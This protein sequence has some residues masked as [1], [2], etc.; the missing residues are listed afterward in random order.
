MARI[1]VSLAKGETDRLAARVTAKHDQ[2]ARDGMPHG[3]AR[4][5]GYNADQLS[6]NEEEAEVV[7]FVF[8]RFLAVRQIRPIVHELNERGLRTREGG[9]WHVMAVRRMLLNPRY[10]AKRFH[11]GALYDAK[12]PA[13]VSLES[14]EIARAT[15]ADPDRKTTPKNTGVAKYL[16]TGLVHCAKCGNPMSSQTRGKAQGMVFSYSCRNDPALLSPG[17]GSMRIYGAWA[18]AFV[19]EAT[20]QRMEATTGLWE[21]VIATETEADDIDEALL[22]VEALEAREQELATMFAAGEITREVMAR[23][24]G[25]ISRRRDVVT[26]RLNDLRTRKNLPI[27]STGAFRADWGE[28]TVAER[29]A[30]LGFVVEKV[31]IHPSRTRGRKFD[32]ERVEIVW[33]SAASS[34]PV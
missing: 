6:V 23:T 20:I 27:T 25:E 5:Y 19:S 9:P 24:S 22:E 16:L 30:I 34:D 26:G 4:T 13:I 2:L 33:R 12:W 28:A 10:V 15:L 21:R 18:D 14:F 1:M 11:K 31:V 29:R 8:E 32:A 3:G 7:R 17:C